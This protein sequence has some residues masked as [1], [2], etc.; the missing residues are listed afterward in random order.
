MKT[1]FILIKS[2]L[3]FFGLSL[4]IIGKVYS[5]YPEFWAGLIIRFIGGFI[6]GYNIHG[7][8]THKKPDGV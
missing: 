7:L 8:I 5:P 2:F 6:A 3:I 1:E 4:V